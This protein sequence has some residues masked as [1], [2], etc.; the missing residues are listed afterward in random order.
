MIK[1]PYSQSG[2][3]MRRISAGDLGDAANVRPNAQSLSP[4]PL[5]SQTLKITFFTARRSPRPGRSSKNLILPPQ[6]DVVG[7][8]CNGALRYSPNVDTGGR[9]MARAKSIEASLLC[10]GHYQCQ[11][12]KNENRGYERHYIWVENVDTNFTK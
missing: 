4:Q 5:A 9:L 8:S 1:P 2:P 7:T 10:A 11:L 6:H 12:Q 3:H